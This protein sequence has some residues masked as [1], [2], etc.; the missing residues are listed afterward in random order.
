M[1]N[2]STRFVRIVTIYCFNCPTNIGC[3]CVGIL[4]ATN[5]D[6]SI[7]DVVLLVD[8]ALFFAGVINCEALSL[9]HEVPVLIF[10][11]VMRSIFGSLLPWHCLLNYTCF[12]HT[13]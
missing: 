4:F 5:E 10:V 6:K 12:C 13:K 7:R 8:A 3:K 9:L 1:S 2:I 11:L